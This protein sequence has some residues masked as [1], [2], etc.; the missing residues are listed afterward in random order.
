RRFLDIINHRMLSLF[1]RAFSS[2]ELAVSFDRKDSQF[3]KLLMALSCSIPRKNS[4]L[5]HYAIKSM[6]VFLS[7]KNRSADG[8]RSMLNM[9]FHHAVTLTTFVEDSYPIPKECR[10]K[11]GE[12]QNSCLGVDA[13]LG[14]HY[15]SRTKKIAITIGPMSFTQ[16]LDFMPGK[17][18]A[19]QL[20]ELVNLYLDRPLYFDLYLKIEV[21][22]IKQPKLNGMFAL[23]QS[24]HLISG[25]K[26]NGITTV[27]ID[28]SSSEL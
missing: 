27:R 21:P 2:R 4:S 16:S 17:I 13:Q 3:E 25:Y 19:R 23:G 22:S 28:M 1:Y 20:M 9:F 14:T 11:L 10:L 7:L 12:K 5:P 15:L 6:D 24:C 8:L 26:N 18:L